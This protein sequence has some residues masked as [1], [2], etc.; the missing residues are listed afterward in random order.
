MYKGVFKTNISNFRF[1]KISDGVPYEGFRIMQASKDPFK[2]FTFL[3][4]KL[5][6]RGEFERPI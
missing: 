5:P 3:M 4:E 6:I 2:T 1:N